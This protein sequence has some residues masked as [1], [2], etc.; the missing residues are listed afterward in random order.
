MGQRSR[1]QGTQKLTTS[2][3]VYF[4]FSFLV[5]DGSVGREFYSILLSLSPPLKSLFMRDDKGHCKIQAPLIFFPLSSPSL[6]QSPVLATS[7]GLCTNSFFKKQQ[8]GSE[9]HFP[10][11][12]HQPQQT[13]KERWVPKEHELWEVVD[14]ASEPHLSSKRTILY[15]LDLSHFDKRE[16]ENKMAAAALSY[17]L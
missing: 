15:S 12:L 17:F 16:R 3:G 6:L 8:H 10:L 14:F 9:R 11:F 7:L 5:G 13:A 2:E 1:G 4:F